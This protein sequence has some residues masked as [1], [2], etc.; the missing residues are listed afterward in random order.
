MAQ[1]LAGATTIRCPDHEVTGRLAIVPQSTHPLPAP[2]L[3][4]QLPG[5]RE[6]PHP[7]IPVREAERR[8]ES[9]GA[10]GL[11]VHAETMARLAPRFHAG[12]DQTLSGLGHARIPVV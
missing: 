9:V 4:R 12:L 11:T 7:S 8:P 1:L 3:P 5:M 6:G 10:I 2:P